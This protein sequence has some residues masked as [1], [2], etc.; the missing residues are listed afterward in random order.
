MVQLLV[1]MRDFRIEPKQ[2]RLVHSRPGGSGEFVLVE[3]VKEGREG[4]KVLPP[5]FIHEEQGGYTS[6]MAEIF[7]VLSAFPARGGG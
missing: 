3:G 5:L 2:L 7:R 4:L 6:E 1:R